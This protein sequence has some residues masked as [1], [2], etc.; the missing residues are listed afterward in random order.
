MEDLIFCLKK[1]NEYKKAST[2]EGIQSLMKEGYLGCSKREYENLN[3]FYALH[4]S[5]LKLKEKIQKS[6]QISVDE[7]IAAKKGGQVKGIDKDY[8]F[9]AKKGEINLEIDPIIFKIM[10]TMI[11]GVVFC[12]DCGISVELDRSNGKKSLNIVIR[13]RKSIREITDFLHLNTAYINSLLLDLPK[14]N[15]NLPKGAALFIKGNR[16][17]NEIMNSEEFQTNNAYDTPI[18][19]VRLDKFRAKKKIDKAMK[20]T[21]T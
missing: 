11:F 16:G 3:S 18:E 14:L 21:K 2:W 20:V 10:G 13:S 17:Y 6:F 4:P 5:F 15:M 9:Q 1:D 19:K 7:I 12:E 8:T